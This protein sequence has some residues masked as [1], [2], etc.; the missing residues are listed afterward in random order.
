MMYLTFLT[1]IF[2]AVLFRDLLSGFFPREDSSV[3][4]VDVLEAK[5]FEDGE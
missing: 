4:V 5:F 3:E 1:V 2:E